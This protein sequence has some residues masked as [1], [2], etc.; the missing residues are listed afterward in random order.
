MIVP[1]C[2]EEFQSGQHRRGRLF[3]IADASGVKY[4]LA[5]MQRRRNQFPLYSRFG[6][7]TA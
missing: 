4:Q 6:G 5:D 7:R 3:A 1:R 2:V